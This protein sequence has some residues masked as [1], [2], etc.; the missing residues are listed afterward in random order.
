VPLLELLLVQKLALLL[1][2]VLVLQLELELQL[3]AVSQLAVNRHQQLVNH[4]LIAVNHQKPEN[5]QMIVNRQQLAV[6][7]NLLQKHQSLLV[8][9]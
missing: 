4:L 6:V 5:R 7:N 8:L 9:Q 1:V 2:L 3:A